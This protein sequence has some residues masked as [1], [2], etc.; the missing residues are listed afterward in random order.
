[1]APVVAFQDVSEGH[2]LTTQ[3]TAFSSLTHR[4]TNLAM[5]QT[6]PK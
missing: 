4:V 5:P 6:G 1:M 2:L 3:N